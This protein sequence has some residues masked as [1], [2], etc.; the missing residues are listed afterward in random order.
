VQCQDNCQGTFQDNDVISGGATIT[1][2]F[3]GVTHTGAGIVNFNRNY[4]TTDVT[5]PI[6]AWAA[7]D[8]GLLNNYKGS[9][10]GGAAGVLITVST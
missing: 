10:S 1:N 8:V 9:V 5:N 2:G 4:F 6:T 3:R 7:G